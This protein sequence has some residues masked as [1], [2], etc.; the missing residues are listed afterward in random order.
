MSLLEV[1]EVRRAGLK[2]VG[3]DFWYSEEH[4][5]GLRNK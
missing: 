5:E 1:V 4:S 2:R 3:V